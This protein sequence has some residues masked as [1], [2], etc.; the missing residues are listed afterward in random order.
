MVQGGYLKKNHFLVNSYR[1]YEQGLVIIDDHGMWYIILV[2][3]FPTKMMEIIKIHFEH[4]L[5]KYGPW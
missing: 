2:Y 4:K 3:F 1:T 5:E